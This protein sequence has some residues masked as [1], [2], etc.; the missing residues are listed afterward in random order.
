MNRYTLM[1]LGMFVFYGSCSAAEREGDPVFARLSSEV[2]NNGSNPK[3]KYAMT[4]KI[5]SQ[6]FQAHDIVVNQIHRF[7]M[8]QPLMDEFPEEMAQIK[9][10]LGVVGDETG[11]IDELTYME[12]PANLVAQVEEPV[13]N[14]D[15]WSFLGRSQEAGFDY[16]LWYNSVR[17]FTLKVKT[18]KKNKKIVVL[19]IL[20]GNHA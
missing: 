3:K 16:S 14:A 20:E 7:A 10:L 1:L 6:I 8:V 15:G 12:A 2:F 5:R 18:N 13:P 11:S 17:N 9:Q 19:E 4:P